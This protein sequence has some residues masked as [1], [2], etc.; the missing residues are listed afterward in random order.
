MEG[1]GDIELKGGKGRLETGVKR[2]SGVGGGDGNHGCQAPC[3]IED[4]KNGKG[5]G[6]GEANRTRVWVGVCYY[7]GV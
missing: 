1:G 5:G 4:E 3:L 6:D 7:M 2:D